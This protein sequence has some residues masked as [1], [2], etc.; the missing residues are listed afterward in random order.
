MGK[1]TKVKLAARIY[2]S[3]RLAGETEEDACHAADSVVGVPPQEQN[4]VEYP[5][6][7]KKAEKTKRP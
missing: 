6:T 2:R 3:M 5:S 4:Y 1:M 7:D